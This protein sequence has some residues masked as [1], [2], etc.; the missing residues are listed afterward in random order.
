MCTLATKVYMLV[1]LADAGIHGQRKHSQ[2]L[3]SRLRGNDGTYALNDGT[4][5]LNDGTYVLN[6]RS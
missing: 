1:I 2:S 3:D 6:G 4:Y 5:V